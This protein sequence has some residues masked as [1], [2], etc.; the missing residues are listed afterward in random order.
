MFLKY[1][2]PLLSHLIIFCI[3]WQ[4]FLYLSLVQSPLKVENASYVCF[5]PVAPTAI[6]CTLWEFTH[7][8]EMISE[9]PAVISARLSLGYFLGHR[10]AFICL[11]ILI[12]QM[13]H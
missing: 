1:T 3:M 12:K 4:L 9:N 2:V 7:I 11:F 13:F 10:E 5:F 6:L 8:C